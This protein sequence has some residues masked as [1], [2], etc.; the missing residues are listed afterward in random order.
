MQRQKELLNTLATVGS[1]VAHVYR[2]D[3][4]MLTL[5]CTTASVQC[6][7]AEEGEERV[8]GTH[9]LR[10]PLIATE[11]RG[12]RVRTCNVHILVMS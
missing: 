4:V 3:V 9:C 11:L 2:H 7:G 10:T 6:S 5:T 1:L 8:P 12:N